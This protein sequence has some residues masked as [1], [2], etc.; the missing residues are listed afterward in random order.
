MAWLM[1][2]TALMAGPTSDP[3]V[4]L[5]GQPPTERFVNRM[6]R[7]GEPMYAPGSFVGVRFQCRPHRRHACLAGVYWI[8]GQSRYLVVTGP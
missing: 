8:S 5:I 3:P 7:V 1:A 2:F 6:L 4:D